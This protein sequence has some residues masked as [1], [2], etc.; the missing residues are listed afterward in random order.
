MNTDINKFFK[1]IRKQQRLELYA[2]RDKNVFINPTEINFITDNNEIASLYYIH[3]C[4]KFFK[5]KIMAKK[6]I[7]DNPECIIACMT[8]PKKTSKQVDNNSTTTTYNINISRNNIP[9][10]TL[11]TILYDEVRTVD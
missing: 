11:R 9:I 5:N 6:H 2:N 3:C 10:D 8:N 4:G 7:N 1:F